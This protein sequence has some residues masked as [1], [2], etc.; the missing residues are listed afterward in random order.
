[1]P[2]LNDYKSRDFGA[3]SFPTVDVETFIQ[4]KGIEYTKSGKWLKMVC[5]LP[6]GHEDSNPSFFIHSEHGGYNCYV[7]GSGN[8][9]DLCQHMNWNIEIDSLDVESVPEAIWKD[10][11]KRIK[12]LEAGEIKE[13]TFHKPHGLRKIDLV[14]KHCAQHLKY[15]RQR[16]LI[17]GINE[18]EIGY[19]INHDCEYKNE[20]L[21]RVIIPCHNKDGKYIWS[22]GRLITSGKTDRKYY[23][24]FGVEKVKYLF[25]L[26]R[27]LQ[28]GYQDVIVVEGIM[29]A[30]NLWLWNFPAVCCYGANISDE[31]IADLMSFDTVILCLDSDPAGIK[32]HVEASQKLIN[33]GI[34]LFRIILPKFQDVNNITLDKWNKLYSKMKAITTDDTKRYEK[35]KFKQQ[36]KK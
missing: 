8:W 30:I 21:N 2:S 25:N 5:I 1:M 7:C 18:F 23:R 29:D 32:G 26:H 15:L 28:A 12:Q 20:Y 17:D 11:A 35:I 14:D 19:T 33:T 34:S 31:Q 3:K 22:E 27:V 16:R 9:D 24:P 36:Q 6:F 13:K 10:T 4:S